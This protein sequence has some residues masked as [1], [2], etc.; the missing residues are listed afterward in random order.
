[1]STGAILVLDSITDKVFE[2]D[3]EGGQD[4]LVYGELEMSWSNFYELLKD[5]FEI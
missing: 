1:M 5:Y 3:F 4:L 2:V